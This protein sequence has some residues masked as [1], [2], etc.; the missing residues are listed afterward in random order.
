MLS[1]HRDSGSNP[2]RLFADSDISPTYIKLRKIMDREKRHPETNKALC[3]SRIGRKH[4]SLVISLD[5][6]R[7]TAD[8][9]S[10]MPGM[11]KEMNRRWSRKRQY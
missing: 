9:R 11:P 1:K 8:S 10:N 6:M 3:S 2:A 5:K 4:A 7:R